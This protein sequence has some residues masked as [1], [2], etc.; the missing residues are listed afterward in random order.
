MT[1]P[2]PADELRTAAARLRALATAATPG[3][4]RQHDTHLG[5]YG[6]TATVLSGERNDTELRAWLPTMSQESWDETR[7]VWADAAYIAA[8]HPGIG[9]A[10]ADWLEHAAQQEAYTLAEWGHRG[11]GGPH[12]LAV[13][14]TINQEQP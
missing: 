2:S 9:L 1:D 14:R 3:P 6:H 10:L 4:W 7:N 12:A 11:G 13:A 5:Q 8:M